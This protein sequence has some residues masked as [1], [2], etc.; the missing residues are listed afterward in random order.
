MVGGVGC[1]VGSDWCTLWPNDSPIRHGGHDMSEPTNPQPTTVQSSQAAETPPPSSK[2]KRRR[3]GRGLSGMIG[4][5]V[6][7]PTEDSQIQSVQVPHADGEPTA[8]TIIAIPVG[9]IIP[10]RNQPRKV[11]EDGSLRSLAESIRADGVMQ[12]ILVRPGSGS[13]STGGR[14]ELIAGERRWRA[15]KIAGLERV[16]AIVREIGDAESAQF[17]L[18]ENIHREDL[19]AIER[20]EAL[21]ELAN[22]FGL[23][24][25]QI[26]QR[27]GL[28]RSTVANLMRLTELEPEIRDMISTGLL[29]GGHGKA[30]LAI[31][32]GP[33]RLALAK[34]AAKESW[35]VRRLESEVRLANGSVGGGGAAARW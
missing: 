6:A 33:K 30:L 23:T 8:P 25:A 28:E 19:T 9:S 31:A 18:I 4:E 22:R 11:F 3:L 5:P 20:G 27:L 13:G 2:T 34:E 35:S 12:P 32:A 29:G 24:Q 21:V 15:A 10:N 26:A 17:A 1:H 16:P 7:V 14:Y